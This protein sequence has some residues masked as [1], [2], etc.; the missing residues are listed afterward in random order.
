MLKMLK[1]CDIDPYFHQEQIKLI[2]NTFTG[3]IIHPINS[4]I[5]LH[6]NIFPN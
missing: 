5:F 3:E 6:L 2:P 1:K 4:N